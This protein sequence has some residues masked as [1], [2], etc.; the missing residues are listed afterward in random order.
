MNLYLERKN[1]NIKI[2][3]DWLAVILAFLLIVLALV[4]VISPAWMKF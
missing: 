2:N 3:E 4:S 1:M